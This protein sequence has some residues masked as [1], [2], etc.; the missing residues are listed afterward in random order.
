MPREAR[1]SRPQDVAPRAARRV[2]MTLQEVVQH[3]PQ[4][5]WLVLVASVQRSREF[6]VVDAARVKRDGCPS[7]DVTKGDAAELV[8][9][10]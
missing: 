3:C 1:D 10:R 6:V 2:E 4:A 7:H 9:L 5:D 8:A